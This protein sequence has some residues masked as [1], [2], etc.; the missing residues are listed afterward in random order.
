MY[1]VYVL[2]SIDDDGKCWLGSK[3]LEYNP[4]SELN[5]FFFNNEQ[6]TKV[7]QRINEID[8]WTKEMNNDK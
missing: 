1:D 2:T 6:W 4:G 8:Q 7:E 5:L 3:Y